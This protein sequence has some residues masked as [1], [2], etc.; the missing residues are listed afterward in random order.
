ME[1]KKYW[2]QYQED[3]SELV[4]KIDRLEIVDEKRMKK[5][6]SSQQ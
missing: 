5:V 1:K 6:P 2:V 3:S 4:Y